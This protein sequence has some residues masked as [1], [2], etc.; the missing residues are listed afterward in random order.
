MVDGSLHGRTALVT[1]AGKRLGRAIALG[2]AGAGAGVVIHYNTSRDEAERVAAEL[3]ALGGRAHTAQADLADPEAL[4]G[5]VPRAVEMAGP[6]HILVNSASIFAPGTVADLSFQGLMENLAI[7]AWA[8]FELSRGFAAQDIESGHIINLLDTRVVGFDPGHAAYILSKH[9]LAQLTR[10]AAVQF[11]PRIAVNAI[12]PG[13]ILPPPGEDEGYLAK[14]GGALPLQRHGGP[15]DIVDAVLY[16]VGTR[17]VTGQV[18]F[19]DGGRHLRE[20]GDGL[21]PD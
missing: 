9:A 17:F 13:L 20:Q 10:M 1:G 21:H 14:L 3:R 7:N 6:L 15:E 5:L 4:A 12:A 2:L 18:I 11:A 8:P 16:L 19:V